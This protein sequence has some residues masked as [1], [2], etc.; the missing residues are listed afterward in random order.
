[1]WF[2]SFVAS[3]AAR[4]WW[5]V[6]YWTPRAAELRRAARSLELGIEYQLTRE[7]PA[8]DPRRQ[9]VE[10]DIDGHPDLV[11]MTAGLVLASMEA[12]P[13]GSRRWRRQHLRA[14]HRAGAPTAS[15]A[16]RPNAAVSRRVRRTLVPVVSVVAAL[17]LGY[18]TGSLSHEPTSSPSAGIPF[19]WQPT[20]VYPPTLAGR[21]T[22]LTLDQ[23]RQITT[24]FEKLRRDARKSPGQ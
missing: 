18:A 20:F 1:M 15:P 9:Q 13:R 24:Y 4:V 14:L 7:L 17:S 19:R 23:K 2:V 5:V 11:P 8:D 10:A 6:R 21:G 12:P 22:D 3:G 16:P